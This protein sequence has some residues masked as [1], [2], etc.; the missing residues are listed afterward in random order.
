M[1]FR[2]LEPTATSTVTVAAAVRDLSQ[3]TQFLTSALL[4]ER[5]TG[6]VDRHWGVVALD[7]DM[8]FRLMFSMDVVG[9]GLVHDAGE[10]AQDDHYETVEHRAHGVETLNQG[11][12]RYCDETEVGRESPYCEWERYF[13]EDVARALRLSRS[14]V[15]LSLI[16][17]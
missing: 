5:V 17:I 2:I 14:R 10:G 4:N 8:S 3:Q 6:A 15:E 1:T 12:T 16:H 13:E 11:L 9:E 7:W